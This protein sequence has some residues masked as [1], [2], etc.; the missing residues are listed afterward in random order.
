MRKIWIPLSC[1]LFAFAMYAW[2]QGRKVG[3]WEVTTTMTW[4]QS[5]F[6]PGMTPPAGSPFSAAPQITQVCL[7]QA[8]LDRYGAPPPQNGDCQISNVKKD[9]HGV[10]A[11]LSC[12]GRMTGK[13]TFESSWTDSDHAK[14]SSHFTGTVQARTGTKPIEWTTSSTSVFK[15]ADCGNVKP[16]PIP[17][18]K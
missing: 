3:L 6:P 10:S 7:T 17:E 5:P 18:D 4:Q 15:S 2:A 16:R 12:T 14:G 8:I 1:C 11:D 13:G 9:E